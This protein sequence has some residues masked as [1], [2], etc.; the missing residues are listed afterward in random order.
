MV[1]L[2]ESSMRRSPMQL[3]VLTSPPTADILSLEEATSWSK[4]T[5]MKRA[6]SHMSAWATQP[7][8]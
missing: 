4:F 8:S 6:M 2:L 7:I 1:H 5:A 3:M